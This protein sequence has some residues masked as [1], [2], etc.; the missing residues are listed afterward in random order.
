MGYKLTFHD[1]DVIIA[2]GISKYKLY[3]K[4]DNYPLFI[5]LMPGLSGKISAYVSYGSI[6][7][8]LFRIP[9]CTLKFFDFVPKNEQ[10]FLRMMN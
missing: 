9:K 4:R 10:L 1:L 2:D 5:V 6:L 8:E 3:G 7:S